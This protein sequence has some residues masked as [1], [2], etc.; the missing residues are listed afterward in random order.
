MKYFV[1]FIMVTIS[2]TKNDEINIIPEC[3]KQE[4]KTFEMSPF[5]VNS[6]VDEYL[7]QNQKVYVFDN[8]SCCCDFTSEVLDGQ[9]NS[10]G[11]LGGFIGNSIING[12]DFSSASFI[13]TLWKK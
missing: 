2:C 9:C 3:I 10:L 4:I 11:F 5:C 8:N 1:F 13:T 7:F 6:K 12:V